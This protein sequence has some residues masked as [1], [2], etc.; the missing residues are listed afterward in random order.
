MI[1]KNSF[2]KISF[3][4][5]K[6][7]MISRLIEKQPKEISRGNEAEKLKQN[8]HDLEN[9]V[10]KLLFEIENGE[11][12]IAEDCRKLKMQVQL[13]REEKIEEI[14]KDCDALFL[15]IDTYEEKC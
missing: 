15:K 3:R 13:V 14:N 4:N 10:N 9:L 2:L 11:Y 8:L 12:L 7:E 5:F 1:N 6:I